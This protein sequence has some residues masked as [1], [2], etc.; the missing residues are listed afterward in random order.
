[1]D[2]KINMFEQNYKVLL[3]EVWSQGE[4]VETRTG[5][6]A[7]AAFNKTIEHD[8]KD[9]FP[10][11]TSKQIFFDK[12]YHEYVWMRDGGTTTEYLNKHDI[13]WWNGYANNG[14]LG[15]IYGYQ[16]R[17]F[18]GV[19]DQIEFA[20]KEIRLNSRRAVINLWNPCDL[21]EQA[22]PVC[23][24][25]FTFVRIGDTLNMQMT[26]RS[27]D[28]FLGLPYDMIIGALLLNDMAKFC[29]LKAGK[30]AYRMDNAHIYMN[31]KN[32]LMQ[33]LELRSY[34]LPRYNDK[35]KEV[36]NKLIGYK[37]GPFIKA[38]LNE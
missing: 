25:G 20:I 11:I 3:S 1:M 16:L 30:I 2:K 36:N 31:H 37:H 14:E 18:N 32:Q 29:E 5:T 27:S 4:E 23:F 12:A 33:Y 34:P 7:M 24:T 6:N 26:F 38:E 13:N 10:I 22:L 9:G 21:G 8:M 35:F 28:L 19:F 17:N 15:K